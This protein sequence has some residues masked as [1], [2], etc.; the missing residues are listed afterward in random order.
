MRLKMHWKMLGVVV[1]GLAVFAAGV[2]IGRVTYP[3]SRVALGGS[4][5]V[6]AMTGQRLE[7]MEPVLKRLHLLLDVHLLHAEVDPSEVGTV[8]SQSP[9]PG[10]MVAV[11]TTLSLVLSAGPHA[12]MF[13]GKGPP[14]AYVGL[15]TCDLYPENYG[16]L[17][18]GGPVYARL[19][20]S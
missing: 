6:P 13:G 15:G 16:T 7:A 2:L 12:Q 11:G 14:K 17:C 8:L 18:A 1:A 19:R 3:T 5:Q 10:Q 9:E 4:V 20:H